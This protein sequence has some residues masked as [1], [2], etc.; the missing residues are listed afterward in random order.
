M[1]PK[2]TFE[3]TQNP[4]W[5]EQ[6]EALWR[7]IEL[8][9]KQEFKAKQI[10]PTKEYFFGGDVERY[11]TQSERLG[12]NILFRDA[13]FYSPANSIEQFQYVFDA[14]WSWVMEK[15]GERAE[16]SI[17]DCDQRLTA[18]CLSL[19]DWDPFYFDPLLAKD[20]FLWIFG[21]VYEPHRRFPIPLTEVQWRPELKFDHN[22]LFIFIARGLCAYLFNEGSQP[23][24]GATD[25]Y[26]KG[27]Y[28]V[29]YLM[30]LMPHIDKT[31]YAKSIL[32]NKYK[33]PT[34]FAIGSHQMAFRAFFACLEGYNPSAADYDN[35]PLVHKHPQLEAEIKQRIGQLELPPEHHEFIEFVHKHKENILDASE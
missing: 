32:G 8:D 33:R 3:Q 4:E 30:S 22:E 34:G 16:H 1:I 31:W 11:T 20:L 24:D 17:A 23:S 14:F 7:P 2:P 18:V 10:T 28:F 15:P 9:L 27:T 35:A 12:M 13:L 6:R 5:F 19:A 21:T 25:E 26:V 29:D